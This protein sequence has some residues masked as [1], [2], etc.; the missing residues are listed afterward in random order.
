MLCICVFVGIVV[1]SCVFYVFSLVCVWVS[2]IFGVRC[3][4]F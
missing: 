1:C 2:W 4:M 3:V